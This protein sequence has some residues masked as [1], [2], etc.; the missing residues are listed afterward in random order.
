MRGTVCQR[1]DRWGYRAD[2]PVR[3]D[4]QRRQTRKT[5]FTSKRAAEAA[6]A[7]HLGAVG[8]GVAVE[9]SRQTL[10]AYL[11]DWL[12]AVSPSLRP[13]TRAQYAHVINAWIVPRLGARPL[14]ELRPQ[15]LQSLYVELSASGRSDNTGGLSP[16]SVRLA[17]LV[18]KMA[19]ARAVEWRILMM[20]PA[21]VRLSLP[22]REEK[23][24][25]TWSAEEAKRFLGSAEKDVLGPL[26]TLLLATGLRRGEALGLQWEDVDMAG[27]RLAV[28]RTLVAVGGKPTASEPKTPAARRSVPLSA[29]AHEALDAQMGRQVTARLGAEEAWNESGMVFTSASGAPLDPN[30]V[31]HA[32]ARACSVAGVQPIRI[33][34]MRHTFAS[35]ALEA[36]VPL[37]VVQEILGHSGISIT[38]D[39]YQHTTPGMGEAAVAKIGGLLSG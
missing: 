5:G 21:A 18:L 25:S 24:M 30:N 7:E 8:R 9:P 31:R 10:A 27:R 34:D 6:L 20:S 17:H 33:H 13:N 26:W 39:V 23:P 36:G 37:K 2:L 29:P 19:L 32:L 11:A 38:S 12:E 14:Q 1:G 15:D 28:V 4:G 22:R 35:L 3:A 16:R